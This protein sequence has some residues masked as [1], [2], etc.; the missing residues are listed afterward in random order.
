MDGK[1]TAIN[2]LKIFE[3]NESYSKS[4]NQILAK[5]MWKHATE[6]NILKLSRTFGSLASS[7][8]PSNSDIESL[9]REGTLSRTTLLS[10]PPVNRS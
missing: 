1:I 4:E 2:R 7:S 9:A 8:S 10:L 6:L 5:I 3:K